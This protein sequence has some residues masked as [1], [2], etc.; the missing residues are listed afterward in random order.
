MN[1]HNMTRAIKNKGHLIII[2]FPSLRDKN[3]IILFLRL[4]LHENVCE[5]F[6][7]SASPTIYK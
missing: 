3:M 2:R 1:I 7:Y 5:Y 6:S 4:N